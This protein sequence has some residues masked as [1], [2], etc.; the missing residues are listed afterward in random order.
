MEFIVPIRTR[1]GVKFHTNLDEYEMHAE[2]CWGT[3][4]V[5]SKCLALSFI[6]CHDIVHV[7]FIVTRLGGMFNTDSDGFKKHGEMS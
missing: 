5:C 6:S 3:Y 1:C 7:E 2:M 4:E